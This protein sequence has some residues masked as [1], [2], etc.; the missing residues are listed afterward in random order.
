M[1]LAVRFAGSR[2]CDGC[3]GFVWY[4]TDDLVIVL[5]GEERRGEERER[6]SKSSYVINFDCFDWLM[7][8]R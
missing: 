2:T 8:N 3:A 4:Y 5:D 6:E 7:D 1:A